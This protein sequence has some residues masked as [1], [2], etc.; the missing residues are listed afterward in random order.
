MSKTYTITLP[1]N[2]EQA[3]NQ[4]LNQTQQTPEETILQLLTQSL[5]PAPP[6][7]ETDPL[8]QLIGCIDSDIPDIAENHDYYI[9]Q[10]LYEEMHRDE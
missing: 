5:A 6:H 7:P 2:L 8:F 9:G 4:T 3:L 1:D 10:A